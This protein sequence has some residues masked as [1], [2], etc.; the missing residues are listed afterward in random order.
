MNAMDTIA[1]IEYAEYQ[2]TEMRMR[3]IHKDRLYPGII[4]DYFRM[5]EQRDAMKEELREF[6]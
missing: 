2:I 4:R 3:I 6:N 5:I 1:N